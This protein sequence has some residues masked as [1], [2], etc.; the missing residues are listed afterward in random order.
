MSF[1]ARYC[2]VRFLEYARDHQVLTDCQLRTARD[3]G[4]DVVAVTSDPGREA[5][6]LGAAVNWFDDAP[7]ALDDNQPRLSG[8]DDLDHLRLPDPLGG[9]RMHECIRGI[10]RLHE[11]VGDDFAVLGWVEGPIAEAVDLYGMGQMMIALYDEPEWCARFFEFIVD[12]ELTYARAQVDA[13]AD[14]IGVGDAAASLLSVD[15]YER[16]VLPA[17]RALIEGIR[18]MGVPVRLHICGRIDQL[19][20]GIATLPVSMVD[21]DRRTDLALARALIPASIPLLGNIDPVADVRVGP[22]Q[23]VVQRLR[24]CQALVGNRFIL[25]AGCELPPDTNPDHVH[26]FLDAAMEI[27]ELSQK[28]SGSGE[29]T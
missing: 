22:R 3:F 23:R 15:L 19:L 8:R 7:P 5:A 24:E 2:G 25:G 27:A 10:A 9:G 11:T 14:M 1:A 16:L 18:A 29:W 13:G 26:G 6:D 21:I 28:G 4:F 20:A 12:M 17:Q